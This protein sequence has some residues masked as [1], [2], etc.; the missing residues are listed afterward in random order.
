MNWVLFEMKIYK[1]GKMEIIDF[2]E[3]AGYHQ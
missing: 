1:N 3:K 2:F